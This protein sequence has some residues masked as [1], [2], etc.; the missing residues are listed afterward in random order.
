MKRILVVVDMQNDF[1]DGILGTPEA[2]ANVAH[3][4]K[5]ITSFDG[6][7]VFT[8]DT[9]GADYLATEEGRHLPVVHCI[10]GTEG[11]NLHPEIEKLARN[12]KA[13][14]VEKDV[15]GSKKL[16]ELLLEINKKEAIA[17]IELLGLCTDICIMVNT[18]LVKTYFP[19]IPIY[20]NSGCSAG[21]TPQSHQN[22]LEAMKMC[23]I[24]II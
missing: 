18:L 21:I 14:V 12:L 8:K 1:I 11:W 2:R 23:H 15:F 5:R 20:V 10:K 7:V 17:S 24:E 9:H 6:T 13:P 16:I 22:A 19:N 3:V 4:V